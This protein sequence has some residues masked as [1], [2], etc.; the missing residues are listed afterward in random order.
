MSLA[1]VRSRAPAAGRAPDVTVEVHLANGLPSFSIV[2]LP[3]VEVRESRERVRAALQNCG[4]DFPVR[5]ITVNLAPADLPKESGRFDLPI[6]LGILAAN[7]QI[8]VDALAGREFAGELSL[9]GALR[10]MRGA[11]AMAC[12]TAR[13]GRA[14]ATR[15]GFG[16]GSGSGAGFGTGACSGSDSN[17][18]ANT[19]PEPHARAPELYL[20][21]DSAAEAALVPGVIVYGAP[22]LPTL[23]AHLAGAPDARLVPVAAPC[24]DGMPAPAAPDLADVVG[25]RG[26]RRALEVAAAGGHHMLMI[27]PPG[28]GKS[29]LAARLPGLLPPLTDDEALTSAALLSASRLGFS[30]AHWRRR[31]F[32]S[33]HHSSSAAA[34]VGGRNPPQ[35]GEIT[36]AHLGVLFLDELPEFDRHVLEMLREPLEGG[37]ITISRAAQQADFPAACQLIAAMNPCPCG[38]HGDPSGR[39]R[40]APDV[41]TRY[42]RKLSGPLLD[43]IDIQIDVPALSV[44]ELAARASAP[45]E[46]SAVV[47]E[48]VA[49]ARAVQLARQGKTNHM[50]SGRETDDLCR[51]TNDGERLLREAGERFGWSARAYFRV[52]KVARTIADLAGD[53]SPTAAQIAEAIRYRRALTA[54]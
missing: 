1:V 8:P 28:A 4:F 23:C 7:G 17:S 31:P 11:F 32:R 52:L 16:S 36:L 2:G 44:A 47:A 24:V 15:D 48:R 50:L 41:A 37:R 43:R 45:G 35:P 3:D 54:L 18:A 9:T 20:P 40:C 33:P 42:L 39:C 26:A 5:R 12:G 14:D 6:A 53:P 46:P 22:D 29:M 13:D 25:Q 21:F 27:G 38:W 19:A 49:R 10:P 30:P 34:L 51:P